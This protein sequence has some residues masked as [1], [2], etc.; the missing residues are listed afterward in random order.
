[1]RDEIDSRPWVAHGHAFF[2]ALANFFADLG[3]IISSGLKRLNE[4][5]IDAPWKRDAGPGHA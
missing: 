5:E 3:T 4:L 2:Q 1:M